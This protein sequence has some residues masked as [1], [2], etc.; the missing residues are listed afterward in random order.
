MGNELAHSLHLREQ[1][2]KYQHLQFSLFADIIDQ[3]ASQLANQS[4][5]QSVNQS[6]RQTI[7]LKLLA[8]GLAATKV[9][10]ATEKCGQRW[11]K[12]REGGSFTDLRVTA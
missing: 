1:C 6:V 12:G 2:D 8:F 11:E 10:K 7:T 4:L 9:A 3:P 5:S